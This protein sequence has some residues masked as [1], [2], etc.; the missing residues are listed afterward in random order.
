MGRYV[1]SDD[2]GGDGAGNHGGRGHGMGFS[3]SKTIITSSWTYW[4]D[5]GRRIFN[6]QQISRFNRYVM[7]MAVNVIRR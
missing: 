2:G 4:K 1:L 6:R 5:I 3:Y 7:M